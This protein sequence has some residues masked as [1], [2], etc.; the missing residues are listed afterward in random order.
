MKHRVIKNLN[1]LSDD[2]LFQEFFIELEKIHEF[3]YTWKKCKNEKLISIFSRKS[4][5][6]ALQNTIN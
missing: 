3:H 6:V 4:K 1:Q 5:E 2:N